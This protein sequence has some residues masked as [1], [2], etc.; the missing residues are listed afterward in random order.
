MKPICVKCQCFY[1]P[2]RNGEIFVEGMPIAPMAKKGRAEPEKWK[3]Y[4]IWRGDLWKCPEC[5][6]EII[7]GVAF[8]PVSEHYMDDFK[9]IYGSLPE[10]T[11][12]VNDC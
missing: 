3:P 11:T 1:R 8:N 6:H 4:K 7:S 10:K 2:E 9:R 12:H 5:G